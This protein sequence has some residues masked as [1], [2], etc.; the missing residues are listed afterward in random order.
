MAETPD[1]SFDLAVHTVELVLEQCSAR[2]NG[3]VV[4]RRYLDAAEAEI[5]RLRS[6][7]AAHEEVRTSAPQTE[8]PSPKLGDLYAIEHDGFVGT[9]IGFYQRSDGYKGVVM[10]QAGTKIVHVYGLKWLSQ[11][12]QR[13]TE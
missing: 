3:P 5:T 7:L 12:D 1:I 13:E 9:V 11:I 10:Q 6:E 4:L 2:G 8:T